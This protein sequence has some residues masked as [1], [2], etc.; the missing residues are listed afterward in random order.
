MPS[1][2]IHLKVASNIKEKLNI[3]EE[4]DKFMIGNI[5]PDMYSAYIMKNMSQN[6]PYDVSHYATPVIINGARFVLPDYEKF[7]NIH[8]E[9]IKDPLVLGYLS[10]LMADHFFNKYTYTNN[11]IIDKSGE[12]SSI[13]T[14]RGETL[15]CSKNTMIRMKQEDFKSYEDRLNIEKL[16]ISYTSDIFRSLENIKAFK[17]KKEDVLNLINYLNSLTLQSSTKKAPLILFSK[18]CL[19]NMI[20]ECSSF[21][22]NYIKNN[23]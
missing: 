14:K 13:K 22:L 16:N 9:N 15:K 4:K 7:K 19:D 3:Y 11:C 8:L 5:I 17:I 2:K 20:E 12:V 21:I 6:I 23:I 10:H 1:W 18:E